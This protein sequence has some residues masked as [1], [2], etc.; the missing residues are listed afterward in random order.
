MTMLFWK[1]IS[2][3]WRTS[4]AY[5][6]GSAFLLTSAYFFH[7][8]SN[9][10]LQRVEQYQAGFLSESDLPS[11]R[12][13][14]IEPYLETVG[15]LLVFLVPILLLRMQSEEQET[16]ATTFLFTLPVRTSELV[17]SRFCA[18]LLTISVLLLI[19]VLPVFVLSFLSSTPLSAAAAG[20]IGLI[21]VSALYLSIGLAGTHLIPSH[22]S[23]TLVHCTTLF[24][25]YFLPA[26]AYQVGGNIGVLLEL[27]SPVMYTEMLFK[28]YCS[29]NQLVYFLVGTLCF[30]NI[31]SFLKHKIRE[32]A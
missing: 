31:A 15:F 5:I 3:W 1:D 18:A 27:L 28:G 2:L 8:Y 12:D 11:I 23:L 25:L 21:L 29:L 32:W 13:M 7:A 10:Y 24:M 26:L 17:Y 19:G 30:L 4:T 14:V 6:C 9:S 22:V 16:R 20:F